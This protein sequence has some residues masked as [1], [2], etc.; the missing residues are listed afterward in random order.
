MTVTFIKIK[1]DGNMD[2]ITC[3]KLNSSNIQKI[4][5]QNTDYTSESMKLQK[6]YHWAY[7]TYLVECYGLYDGEA[8]TE[9]KHELIPN[10]ISSFLEEDSSEIL[11]F[12]DIFVLLKEKEKYISMDIAKYGEIHEELCG[13]FDDCESDSEEEEEEDQINT[14]DEQFIDDEECSDQGDSDDYTDESIDLDYDQNEYL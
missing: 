7:E 4:L 5:Y 9:N 11:L 1:M 8:G 2:E 14:D 6:L 10:G 12:G 3:K 13:G